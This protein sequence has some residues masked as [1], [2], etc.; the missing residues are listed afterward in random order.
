MCWMAAIPIAMSAG[1]MMMQGQ[2]GEQAKAAQIDQSR[3]QQKEMIRSM[4]IED[5]NLTM[6]DRENLENT[7]GEMT[8]QN[9]QK[10]RAMSTIRTAIGEGMLE[11]KSMERVERVTE[12]DFAREQ[13]GLTDSYN[14]DY[15][16]IFGQRV[17]NRETT[18]S[19]IKAMQASEPRL[20]GRLENMIDP[21][22]IGLGKLVDMSIA[23]SGFQKKAKGIVGKIQASDA[24]ST[25]QAS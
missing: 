24:K 23:G 16:A 11:G 4:N 22:G 18:V 10:V 14:R 3:K 25:G 20:K 2:Q 13:Q 15:A 6:Q 1:Q 9:M 12:G 5:A 8:Q 7:V 17:S 19:Q 21:L